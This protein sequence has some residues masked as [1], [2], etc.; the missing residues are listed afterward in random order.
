MP[1]CIRLQLC[2]GLNQGWKQL[3]F[4]YQY[5]HIANIINTSSVHTAL[6]VRIELWSLAHWGSR[7]TPA[8]LCCLLIPCIDCID[9]SS[10]PCQPDLPWLLP[11]LVV[12][13]FIVGEL[14][15]IDYI[16]EF[17]QYII[18][19]SQDDIWILPKK[20]LHA[21]MGKGE[22][23]L[24]AQSF[25]HLPFS[26]LIIYEDSSSALCQKLCVGMDIFS[27]I[28]VWL[29]GKSKGGWGVELLFFECVF[30]AIQWY[31]ITSRVCRIDS[32]LCASLLMDLY[33][34]SPLA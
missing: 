19:L 8:P 33:E 15:T 9:L 30:T 26:H 29:W 27:K 20:K 22:R 32:R 18:P 16:C 31:F 1:A 2:Y 5:G 13:W 25:S 14:C 17:I 7:S 3:L 23:S 11:L 4:F 10:M 6:V 21:L 28:F 24:L 12:T 34:T